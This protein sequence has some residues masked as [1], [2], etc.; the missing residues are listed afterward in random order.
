MYYY[1]VIDETSAERIANNAELTDY[2]NDGYDIYEVDDNDVETLIA[3]EGVWIEAEPNLENKQT[4]AHYFWADSDGAHI[5]TVD[6]VADQGENVL[7]DSNGFYVR[8]GTTVLTSIT[9]GLIR[10][11]KAAEER[12]ELMPTGLNLYCLNTYL[13]DSDVLVTEYKNYFNVNV[14]TQNDGTTTLGV[15]VGT[16]SGTTGDL[17]FTSGYDNEASGRYSV[18]VGRGN[19]ASGY[20]SV[21]LGGEG[22]QATGDYSICGGGYSIASA[23]YAIAIGDNVRATS[24][25][26]I[27]LGAYNKVSSDLLFMIGNGEGQRK[28][29][30]AVSNDGGLILRAPNGD[31]YKVTITNNGS[32]AVSAYTYS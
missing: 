5:S 4:S 21:C 3:S 28:N 29:A 18:S 16:R 26:Q 1:A 6:G 23:S 25:G 15:T 8:N 30:F 2:F 14:E 7:M 31:S 27:A 13:D 12:L 11:G 24:L 17:S 22:N 32:F 19:V 10:I 9:A 20:T